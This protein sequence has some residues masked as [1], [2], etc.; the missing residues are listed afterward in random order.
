M[1]QIV[2]CVEFPI[3]IPNQKAVE[4]VINK[5]TIANILTSLAV[6]ILSNNLLYIVYTFAALL[7]ILLLIVCPNWLFK[8]QPSIEWLNIKY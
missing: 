8:S 1:D 2:E 3:T 4:K 6:G 5:A 7:I